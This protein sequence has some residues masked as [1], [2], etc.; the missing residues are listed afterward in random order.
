MAGSAPFCMKILVS[1]RRPMAAAMCRGVSW[2]CAGKKVSGRD[3]EE[4][5]RSGQLR[6]PIVTWPEFISRKRNY[7]VTL[8]AGEFVKQRAACEL[9]LYLARL[10]R[11][12]WSACSSQLETALV[13][14]LT[15]FT[16]FGSPLALSRI[17]ATPA[18]P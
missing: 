6:A 13:L 16:W 8:G 11:Q 12:A 18:C 1:L 3:E 10:A 4:H 17:R 7:L 2:F 5:K 14:I 15:M 9:V